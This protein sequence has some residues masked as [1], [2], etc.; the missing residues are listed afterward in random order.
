MRKLPNALAYRTE[1]AIVALDG[2]VEER[3]GYIVARTPSNPSYWWGNFLLFRDA[4][5]PDAARRGHDGSWLDA[6]ARELPGVPSI[7]LAWDRPDGE[8]GAADA[9]LPFGFVRDDGTTLTATT[10]HPPPR[11]DSAIDVRARSRTTRPGP[12]P[13]AR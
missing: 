8:A 11:Y 9:F 5:G 7:L 10:V 4:P 3:D 1:L 12:R 6:H 2:T 13:R